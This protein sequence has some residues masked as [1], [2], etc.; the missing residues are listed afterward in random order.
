MATTLGAPGALKT[1][2]RSRVSKVVIFIFLVFMML[3]YL[4]PVYVMVMNGLKTADVV[5]FSRMWE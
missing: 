2:K 1:G 5:S 4:I 3:I